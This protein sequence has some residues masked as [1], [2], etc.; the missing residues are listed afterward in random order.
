MDEMNDTLSPMGRKE[1]V[2]M[3]GT[4][5]PRYEYAHT[6]R[7]EYALKLTRAPRA[8]SDINYFRD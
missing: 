1:R 4:D 2:Y 7:Y 6:P 5:T 3:P 8:W